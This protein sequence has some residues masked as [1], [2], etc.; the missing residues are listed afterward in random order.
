[1]D[2][3]GGNGTIYDVD[4]YVDQKEDQYTVDDVV[5]QQGRRKKLTLSGPA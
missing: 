5:L 1:V 2:F 3:K 4:F